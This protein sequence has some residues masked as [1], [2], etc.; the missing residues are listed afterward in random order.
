M[1]VVAERTTPSQL[2]T[3]L[4]RIRHSYDPNAT[5]RDEQQRY[6]RRSFD[7]YTGFE[8]LDAV[9]GRLDREVGAGLR[10]AIE[11][12][13]H[14]P[15][16]DDHR[17]RTQRCYDAFGQLVRDWLDRGEVS[18]RGAERPHLTVTI[19][20][21]TLQHAPSSPAATLDRHGPISSEAARR[22]ACD[23]QLRRA[24]TD[25]ASQIL[26]IGRA[27]R[28]VPAGMRRALAL[29]DGG[30]VTCGDPASW[31]DAHH[32]THWADGGTTTLEN[33]VLLCPQHHRADHEGRLTFHPKPGSGWQTHPPP[34]APAPIPMKYA[35][36][37]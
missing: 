10:I 9:S 5:V 1:I 17:S 33:L 13:L 14:A 22:L 4:A 12:K 35:L 34:A 37:G 31:C 6:A 25:G 26:D 3:Y 36:I 18:D 28:I 30:C 27:T 19:D 16:T 32:V 21:T 24:I 7:L 15:A 2:R 23:A 20:I 29:R 8:R 11:A